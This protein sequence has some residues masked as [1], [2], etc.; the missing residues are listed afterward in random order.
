[1]NM[2]AACTLLVLVACSA[3]AASSPRGREE[4]G[5]PFPSLLERYETDRDALRRAYGVPLSLRRAERMRKFYEES[6][7]ELDR[8][9][10]DALGVE[11]RIDHALFRTHLGRELRHLALESKKDGEIAALVPFGGTIAELEESRRRMETIDPEKAADRLMSLAKQ[12][13]EARKGAEKAD[14]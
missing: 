14:R 7:K 5:N 2:R 8:A 12:V 9:D 11:G 6:R 3:P 13:A 10:F 1:M 4:A